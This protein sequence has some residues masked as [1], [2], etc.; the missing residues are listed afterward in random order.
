MR[1][2][3]TQPVPDLLAVAVIQRYSP[4]GEILDLIA[5]PNGTQFR[6]SY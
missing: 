5:E 6:G 4:H 1:F 3:S 2:T